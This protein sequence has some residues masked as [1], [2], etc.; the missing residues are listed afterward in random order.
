MYVCAWRMRERQI[1]RE[2][3]F[4]CVQERIGS[5]LCVCGRN[6]QYACERMEQSGRQPCLSDGCYSSENLKARIT[7][8]CMYWQQP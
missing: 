2:R 6:R 1:E 3:V 4:V 7:V 8:A 5:M